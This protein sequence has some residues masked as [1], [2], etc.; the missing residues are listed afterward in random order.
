MKSELRMKVLP[1]CTDIV[2]MATLSYLTDQVASNVGKIL[3][4]RMAH[5]FLRPHKNLAQTTNGN[6]RVCLNVAGR[7]SRVD[8]AGA[9]KCR[10]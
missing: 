2:A 8:V 1:T 5:S 9:G 3:F 6:S 7:D 10:G 4:T